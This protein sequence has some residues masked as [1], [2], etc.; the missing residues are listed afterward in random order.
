MGSSCPGQRLQGLGATCWAKVGQRSSVAQPN[1]IHHSSQSIISITC[2]IIPFASQAA[3]LLSASVASLCKKRLLTPIIQYLTVHSNKQSVRDESTRRVCC[4]AAFKMQRLSAAGSSAL[5]S[6]QVRSA[7][8]Q[9]PIRFLLRGEQLF[10]EQ[11]WSA[12]RA[13]SDC[14]LS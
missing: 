8:D 10:A 5:C 7:L 11:R 12:L 13:H 9:S 1:L 2:S 6:F 14:C 4:E 3:S